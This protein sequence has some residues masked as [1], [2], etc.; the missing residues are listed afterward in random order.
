MATTAENIAIVLVAPQGGHNIGSICR[1]MMNFGFYDLR[2]VNPRVDHLGKEARDMAVTA[3][4]TVLRSARKYKSLE[5]AIAD[6]HL[7]IGSTRRLG[8]KYRNEFIT[9]DQIGKTCDALPPHQ[10]V[11]LV[12]GREDHGLSNDELSL[13]DI[14]ITIDTSPELPSLNLAQAVTICLY[15]F[16]RQEQQGRPAPSELATAENK[17]GMIQHMRQTLLASGYLDPVNPDHILRTYRRI[18]NRAGLD[19]REVRMLHGLWSLIDRQ[20]LGAKRK[21]EVG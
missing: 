2:I 5:G 9:P 1:V 20:L 4:K 6:C 3:K 10:K 18:F 13:C 8:K 17:E 14:F 16:S 7:V 11:A 15:E 19:E 12:F 21:D